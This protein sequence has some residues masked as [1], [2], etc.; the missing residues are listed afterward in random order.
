MLMITK[1]FIKGKCTSNPG[2]YQLY[3][4]SRLLSELQRYEE[5]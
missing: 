2:F 3:V 1:S 4:S 5:E